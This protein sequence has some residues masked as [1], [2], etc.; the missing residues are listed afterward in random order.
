MQQTSEKKSYI[1]WTSL[2]AE[3]EKSGLPYNDSVGDAIL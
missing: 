2:I 1:D 3:Q